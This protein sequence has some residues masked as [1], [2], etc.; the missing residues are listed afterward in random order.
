M[1]GASSSTN[2]IDEAFH[3]SPYSSLRKGLYNRQAFITHAASHRQGFPHC[4]LFLA[5]ASRRSLGRVSVPVWPFT[6]SG[7]L[8]IVALVGH[9]PTNK[10]MERRLISRWHNCAFHRTFANARPHAVLPHVSMSYPPPGGRSPTCYSPVRHCPHTRRHVFR[11]TCMLKT[12][13]QRSF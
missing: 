8:S 13:R 10:L 12:R 6:L 4:G 9:Y 2:V 1:A 5:A 11:S 3:S 7:R